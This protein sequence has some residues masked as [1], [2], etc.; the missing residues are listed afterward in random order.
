M[1]ALDAPCRFGPLFAAAAPAT[2]ASEA[3]IAIA[4]RELRRSMVPPLF[5]ARRGECLGWLLGRLRLRGQMPVEPF[6]RPPPRVGEVLALVPA[7]ALARI[8]HELRFAAPFDE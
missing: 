3:S 7:V 6:L 2:S 8:H 5:R 1:S 4:T